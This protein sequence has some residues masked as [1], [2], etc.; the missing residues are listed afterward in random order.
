VAYVLVN[1]QANAKIAG[2]AWLGVGAV[3][4][5]VVKARGGRPGQLADEET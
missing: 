1:A 3:M 5:L 2:L 4:L